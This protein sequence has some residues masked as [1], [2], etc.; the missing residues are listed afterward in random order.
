MTPRSALFARQRLKLVADG[1]DQEGVLKVCKQPTMV[2]LLYNSTCGPIPSSTTD[3]AFVNHSTLKLPNPSLGARSGTVIAKHK[4][5]SH[6][7]DRA[8]QTVL[9]QA[10]PFVHN[11]AEP[12]P[13]ETIFP[14]S[15]NNSN[16]IS[17]VQDECARVG[18]KGSAAVEFAGLSHERW[19][20]KRGRRSHI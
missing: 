4:L 15:E 12:P 14:R 20:H 1:A 7:F 17:Q 10:L 16:V 2:L 18:Q 3:R 19:G 8:A 11:T 9:V 13:R 5:E 6:P